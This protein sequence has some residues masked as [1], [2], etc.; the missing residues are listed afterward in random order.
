M[1]ELPEVNT[2]QRYFD[3]T[4]LQQK[5]LEVEVHDEKIL[6]NLSGQDFRDQLTNRTFTGS[7]R[8]GKYLFAELDNG[9]HLLLHFGMTGD[10]NYYQA[11][12]DRTRFERFAFSFANGFRLGF[13]DP[14]KFARIVYIE[15]LPAYIEEVPLGED[16]L[17][18]SEADFLAKMEGRKTSL[19]GFL[20]NQ[21]HLAGVG[22]LYADE[23]CFQAR[24]HPGSVA[25]AIPEE[26][27]VRLFQ[28]M[29]EILQYAV[30]RQ[31]YYKEY[32][33]DWLWQW[34]EE[35]RPG[36]EGIGVMERA[37]IGGRTTYFCADYQVFYGQ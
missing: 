36:P 1:P 12:E 22:N 6:R 25:D 23:I 31:A 7:Y 10:L 27:R 14:R 19:K 9:H 20:L 32:P 4:S 24:V 5:I 29:Q 3:E 13:D 33:E 28:K 17:R 2:F 8:R 35:G 30:D 21:G 34:R 18:I 26:V 15:D 16:A 11:P 37:T